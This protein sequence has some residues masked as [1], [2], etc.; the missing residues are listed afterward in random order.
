MYFGKK[1]IIGV[2]CCVLMDIGEVRAKKGVFIISKHISPSQAQVYSI[3]GNEVNLQA[4]VNISTYNQGAGAVGL[5]GWTEKELMFVTYES[6]S[7]VVWTSTKSVE[8]VGDFNTGVSNLSGIAVDEENEK[9]YI[10]RRR[11]GGTLWTVHVLK[12]RPP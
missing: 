11:S 4:D 6:S 3:D 12:E 2:M 1:L 5:A 7:V 10:V 9:I 8:K